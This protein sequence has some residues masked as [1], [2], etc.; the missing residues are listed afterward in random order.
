MKIKKL[1]A[2]LLTVVA[3][4]VSHAYDIEVDGI[5]YNIVD[6]DHLAVTYRG[7]YV[8]NVGIADNDYAGD[9]T[10]PDSVDIGS[11]VILP[12]KEVGK[13][14]FMNCSELHYVKLPPTIEKLGFLTFCRS[15][16]ET[17]DLSET[18]IIDTNNGMC[19]D[20]VNLRQVYFP[21]QLHVLGTE[22]F[23]D[24]GIE[25]MTLPDNTD[26]G[27]ECFQGSKIRILTLGKNISTIGSWAFR[28][29]RI[30]QINNMESV[31]FFGYQS[32]ARVAVK[33]I[34]IGAEVLLISN[35]FQYLFNLESVICLNENPQVLGKAT[36]TFDGSNADCILW[37]PDEYLEAYAS[38][39]S[40]TCFFHDI[41]PLSQVKLEEATAADS[42]AITLYDLNGRR[43][44]DPRPGQICIT[45]DGR[46]V[47]F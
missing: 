26:I 1:L 4:N 30:E 38:S 18:K 7:E 34:V 5:C 31:K 47:R 35:S 15:G 2:G 32:V 42:T 6:G 43:V 12:V 33:N 23:A 16:I 11:G 29:S 13:Y 28:D 40:V 41:R 44:S 25:E 17:L 37:V 10:I 39:E 14:A 27:D 46:K 3:A 22:S 21:E 36:D 20:C 45:S 19:G 8:A 24:S 9:I